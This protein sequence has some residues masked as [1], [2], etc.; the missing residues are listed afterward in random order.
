MIHNKR[1]LSLKDKQLEQAREEENK[2]KEEER[3]K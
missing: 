1:L 2:R 3:K